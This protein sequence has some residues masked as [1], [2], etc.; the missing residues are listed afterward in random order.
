MAALQHPLDRLEML[1]KE[2]RDA[3]ARE[4]PPN[5]D[6]QAGLA[7]A[8]DLIE[9]VRREYKNAVDHISKRRD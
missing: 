7:H 9:Q 3:G 6:W 1:V 8:L 4:H 2:A 5:P